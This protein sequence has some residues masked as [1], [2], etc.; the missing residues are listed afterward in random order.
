MRA[1]ERIERWSGAGCSAIRRC[2]E[3]LK[4]VEANNGGRPKKTQEDAHPSFSRTHA[5]RDVGLSEHQRKTALR[6]ANLD[7]LDFEQAV[8]DDDPPPVSTSRAA[9]RGER[10]VQAWAAGVNLNMRPAYEEAT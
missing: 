2:G 8:D 3:L 1:S 10:T 6:V 7:E 4:Q 5:A 9:F